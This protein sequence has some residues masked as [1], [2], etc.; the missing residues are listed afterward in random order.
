MSGGSGVLPE[1]ALEKAAPGTKGS[2]GGVGDSQNFAN[3][4]IGT[5][6]LIVG[7]GMAVS[8]SDYGG[9]VAGKVFGAGK[10]SAAKWMHDGMPGVKGFSG[11][12][13]A[14]T[15]S[16][17]GAKILGKFG[18]EKGKIRPYLKKAGEWGKSENV[19]GNWIS[20]QIGLGRLRAG[21]PKWTKAKQ[22]K[23]RAEGADFGDKSL[24]AALETLAR[25]LEG[26]K[27]EKWGR[28]FSPGGVE[29]MVETWQHRARESRMEASGQTAGDAA[30]WLTLE[31]L[32]RKGKN[33]LF[34]T[35][36]TDKVEKSE[37]ELKDMKMRSDAGDFERYVREALED[38]KGKYKTRAEGEET[39]LNNTWR[40]LDTFGAPDGLEWNKIPDADRELLKNL[41]IGKDK[42][43]FG[44]TDDKQWAALQHFITSPTQDGISSDDTAAALGA[45]KKT[46]A[47]AIK[48]RLNTSNNQ[49]DNVV[50]TEE[51]RKELVSRYI[52]S[53]LL[54]KQQERAGIDMG[55]GGGQLQKLDDIS[56]RNKDIETR[57][58]E[59]NELLGKISG[60][61]LTDPKQLKQ[62]KKQLI[63]LK[64]IEAAIQ[65]LSGGK[66]QKLS[67][68]DLASIT[69]A[70]GD[71]D[72]ETKVK[73][74]K[75]EKTNIDSDLKNRETV[76]SKARDASTSFTNIQSDYGSFEE[77]EAKK[78]TLEQAS[79]I[80]EFAKGI[81]IAKFDTLS[82]KD[83]LDEI[84]N[85]N[86]ATPLTGK[87]GQKRQEISDI[88]KKEFEKITE[89]EQGYLQFLSK[90]DLNTQ[91]RELRS[92]NILNVHEFGRFMTDHS[93]LKDKSGFSDV[94]KFTDSQFK[95]EDGTIDTARA[96]AEREK[97]KLQALEL[98][99]DI[100]VHENLITDVVDKGGLTPAERDVLQRNMQKKKREIDG[101]KAD[102][103][104][105]RSEGEYYR[106]AAGQRGM[107]EQFKHIE[108]IEDSDELCDVYRS[109]LAQ[110]DKYLAMAALR[111]LAMT[112]N[113]NDILCQMGYPARVEGFNQFVK[114][115]MIGQL[116]MDEQEALGFQSDIAYLAED[117]NH[118][119]V[120]RSVGSKYG[121]LVQKNP[122]EQGKAVA[123]E[124]IK[125]P[126][127]DVLQSLNRLGWGGENAYYDGYEMGLYT[128]PVLKSLASSIPWALQRGQF[129]TNS[130]FNLFGREE[131]RKQIQE[132]GIEALAKNVNIRASLD[133]LLGERIKEG[134]LPKIIEKG[135]MQAFRARAA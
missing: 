89:L 48:D 116:G 18:S 17:W 58:K 7:T 1:G 90:K 13:I 4:L 102:I 38:T 122:I 107:Q 68:F 12:N 124:L 44:I 80:R 103:L 60:L 32:K 28:R 47:D 16:R 49:I 121:K 126:P 86:S 67:T 134:A 115:T 97:R 51:G 71:T 132:Y 27:T 26:L 111:K 81:G 70:S 83:L 98:D 15:G 8:S 42:G 130:V 43:D 118:W 57:L 94:Y 40:R 41:I 29:G 95:R 56:A 78:K 46:Q 20:D 101:M 125:R 120:A 117:R 39:D 3:F 135:V 133:Q 106:R 92:K 128:L 108:H 36:M 6:L 55:D 25:A 52:N 69:E 75:T 10:A 31:G 85:K 79:G 22:D 93:A 74:M 9:K 88:Y 99:R 123:N 64:N 2:Y 45:V 77:M 53:Q 96:K 50:D 82:V 24:A 76:F 105:M 33:L 72:V 23:A 113:E 61:D 19:K 11:S 91:M 54:A 65:S 119:G 114:D 87:D 37:K 131:I 62:A 110:K 30:D 112:Y 63:E 14:S 66:L 35:G 129:N 73:E 59:S 5:I 127:I 34:F 104:G 100:K 109:A 84:E 21:L